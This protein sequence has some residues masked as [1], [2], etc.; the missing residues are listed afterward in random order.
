MS[1]FCS[2]NV[3]APLI[4][5]TQCIKENSTPY[6]GHKAIGILINTL[7]F[8]YI[9]HWHNHI[10]N[11]VT[12]LHGP[13]VQFTLSPQF[14]SYFS[15]NQH[16]FPS[17]LIYLL[18]LATNFPLSYPLHFQSSLVSIWILIFTQC[19]NDLLPY[20]LILIFK[21]NVFPYV[22]SPDLANRN[23]IYTIHSQG[24]PV[25]NRQ[26]AVSARQGNNWHFLLRFPGQQSSC[27]RPRSLLSAPNLT[28][29]TE[30]LLSTIG[31]LASSDC[32]QSW[33]NQLKLCCVP[34]W[35]PHQRSYSR[36]PHV[37]HQQRRFLT[38]FIK[39]SKFNPTC[40]LS[41]L[42]IPIPSNHKPIWSNLQPNVWTRQ[43]PFPFA[44]TM[45][46]LVWFP[47]TY[48][49]SP[50]CNHLPTVAVGIPFSF[51]EL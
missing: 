39:D 37:I 26:L 44:L 10:I 29:V 31:N 41:S 45:A 32:N 7:C 50:L 1:S 30:P 21:V 14:Y 27:S 4:S 2:P 18:P 46:H 35:I 24:Q 25:I 47:S 36:F 6:F 12:H 16:F 40:L 43:P 3:E 5:N 13:N 48:L 51:W 33:F 19:P 42:T 15:I 11:P 20:N 34:L 49:D 17:I 22:W 8:V 38:G 9:S 23:Q 28:L